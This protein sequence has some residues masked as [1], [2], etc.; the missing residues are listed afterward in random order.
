MDPTLLGFPG[1]RQV[2]NI[3]PVFVHFPIALF[4][5]A[6]LLYTVGIILSR[7]SWCVAG[8]ACLSLGAIGAALAIATGLRAQGTIP[9]N[10]QIHHLMET[11]ET[12]GILV[13]AVALVLVGWSFA[14]RDQ[15]PVGALGFLLGLLGA[16]YLVLQNG[17]LGGRL[18]F[19]EGA[20]VKAAVP[21]VAGEP[22]PGGHH[23]PHHHGHDHAPHGDGAAHGH[24]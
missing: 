6:L 20:G 23:A 12:I 22:P 2:F 11:H 7:R 14:H 8:R 21:L 19:V 18:V 13:G 5:S 17:D 3:H 1:V 15:R 16:S 24:P 9:H 4:P 10:D